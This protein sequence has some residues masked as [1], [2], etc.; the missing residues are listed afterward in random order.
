MTYFV[1]M[2]NS[3][4]LV[5]LFGGMGTSPKHESSGHRDLLLDDPVFSKPCKYWSWDDVFL[6]ESFGSKL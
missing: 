2:F 3:P 5:A 1:P 4:N 6:Q